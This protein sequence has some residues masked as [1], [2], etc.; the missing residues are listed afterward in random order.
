MHEPMN[1]KFTSY[2]FLTFEI[3]LLSF[4]VPVCV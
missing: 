2:V 1:I 4:P 3:T